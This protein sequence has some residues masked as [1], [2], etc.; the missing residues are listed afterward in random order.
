MAGVN[1][2][3]VLKALEKNKSSVKC[4]VSTSRLVENDLI[5]II[6][7]ALRFSKY[8]G[9]MMCQH[10]AFKLGIKFV[11]DKGMKTGKVMFAVLAP[12]KASNRHYI[13]TMYGF[14]VMP[15]P[16]GWK[17]IIAKE[18]KLLEAKGPYQVALSRPIKKEYV[19]LAKGTDA[20]NAVVTAVNFFENFSKK[21]FKGVL[22][23]E[24]IVRD[25]PELEEK[26]TEFFIKVAEYI[27][28]FVEASLKVAEVEKPAKPAP[29]KT[30][31][32][33][34]QTAPAQ[35]QEQVVKP[36]PKQQHQQE[37]QK[38]KPKEA[39]EKKPVRD[40]VGKKSPLPVPAP[41]PVLVPAPAMQAQEKKEQEK[42]K[43]AIDV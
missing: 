22:K 20:Y 34:P 14:A 27:V 3:A 35:Q 11:Y 33:A 15:A 16:K 23:A 19:V 41:S 36:A 21:F 8:D 12:H 2:K 1:V 17:L 25:W 39:E 9:V 4:S 5:E 32:Q 6:R 29:V 40:E 43:I 31:A 37:E 38:S 30:P 10:Q 18:D 13:Q 26:K 42:K 7:N 28:Q 24:S